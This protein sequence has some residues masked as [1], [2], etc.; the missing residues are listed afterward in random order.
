MDVVVLVGWLPKV[1]PHF[2]ATPISL[3]YYINALF[4]AYLYINV[5][6]NV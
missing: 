5:H 3:E 6:F 4:K 1:I 2:I